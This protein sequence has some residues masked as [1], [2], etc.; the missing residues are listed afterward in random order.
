MGAAPPQPQPEKGW[1]VVAAQLE[2]LRVMFAQLVMLMSVTAARQG[3]RD[4][5]HRHHQR[6]R[7]EIPV[8]ES[9]TQRKLG[10]GPPYYE[11][12]RSQPRRRWLQQ[13]VGKGPIGPGGFRPSTNLLW[14][15]RLE[16]RHSVL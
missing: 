3:R 8:E 14:W 2:L 6:E 10:Q 13:H 15:G 1:C 4:R 16:S 11:K 12:S 5:T 7:D 9:A